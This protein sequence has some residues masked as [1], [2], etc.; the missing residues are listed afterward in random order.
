MHETDLLILG[1]CVAVPALRVIE[2]VGSCRPVIRG[3]W[4]VFAPVY[5]TC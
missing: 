3:S 1:L 5:S 2:D 4:P